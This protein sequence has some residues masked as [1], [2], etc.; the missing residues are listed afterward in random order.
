MPAH[1]A[2]ILGGGPAGTAAAI[3]LAA[4]GVRAVMIE[5][6]R[7][8]RDALCGGFLSWRSLRTLAALGVTADELNR[9]RIVHTRL[10]AGGRQ[11][12]A[13]LPAPALAVSR[14]RLD[15]LLQARAGAVAGIE[16]GVAVRGVIDGQVRLAD[17]GEMHADTLFLA[18]GKHDLRG[19]ARP[20]DARGDDPALGLRV[21][22]AAHPALARLVGDAVE[23]HLFRRGYAG[24]ARQEDGSVNLCLAVRRS[25]LAAAGS[26]AALLAELGRDNPALGERIAF[27]SGDPAIDAVANVP[28]GWRSKRGQAGLFRLGDQAGVIPSLA[29]EGMGIALASGMGAATAYLRG[30]PAAAADWQPRFARALVRPLRVAGAVRTVAEGGG[31]AWLVHA[32]HPALIRIIAHATRIGHLGDRGGA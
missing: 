30:G 15:T 31:A 25:R 23:L 10:F 1:P 6:E 12:E 9:E 14:H 2:L 17:G 5:R 21:R 19:L 16:R 22:L 3:A 27:M 7:E 28:Y 26:P 18:T 13:Q 4:G 11:A 8:T 24:I 29:G 20:E 32:A